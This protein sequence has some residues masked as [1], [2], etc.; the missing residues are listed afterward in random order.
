MELV[1]FDI[2]PEL[3]SPIGT[4]LKDICKCELI[5]ISVPTPMNKDGSC[6]LEILH[7]VIDNLKQYTDFNDSLVIIR[8]TV[9]PGTS[10]FLNCFFMPEFLTEK[11]FENDFINCK[12]WI[13]GLKET[14]QDLFFKEKINKL[15]SLAHKNNKIKYNTVHFVTNGEAEMIKMFRN[16]YLAVKVSFCN[17]ISQFCDLK[18]INYENVRL[19][20]AIDDRI[21]LS[22]TQVPGPDGKTG[23]GGTCFPKDS[24]SLRFEMKNI[25]MKSYIIN[26][27]IQRNIEVDRIEQD[28]F[29]NKGRAVVE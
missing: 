22:H 18:N 28:W 14:H 21:G 2:V 27:A 20:A 4:N 15:F 10:K 26:A 5:F 29:D 12:K 19:L 17:E 9:P 8:S 24:N 3:C 23:F 13:F 11:N 16:N 1:V 25:D 6:Y 7:S